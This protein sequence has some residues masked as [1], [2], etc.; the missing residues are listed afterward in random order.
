MLTWWNFKEGF[1]FFYSLHRSQLMMNEFLKLHIKS[2][3]KNI[4]KEI[5]KEKI[6]I[7][8]I[9]FEQHL[10]NYQMYIYINRFDVYNI[11]VT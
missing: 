9:S 3:L 6:K 2:K 5:N 8:K 10:E 1:V 4:W 7:K 11:F